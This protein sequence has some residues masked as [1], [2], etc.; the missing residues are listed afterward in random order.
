MPSYKN[1]LKELMLV[2]FANGD[3]RFL[4]IDKDWYNQLQNKLEIKEKF[5]NY[6]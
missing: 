1:N 6:Y 4:Q 3:V 5:E 2:T